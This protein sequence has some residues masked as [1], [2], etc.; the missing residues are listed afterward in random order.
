MVK[1]PAPEESDSSG[2]ATLFFDPNA[3]PATVAGVARAYDTMQ[4][5]AQEVPQPSACPSPFGP[6]G[7]VSEAWLAFHQAWSAEMA[8]ARSALEEMVKILPVTGKAI[9]HADQQGSP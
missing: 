8:T 5:I 9:V 1:V 4:T 2:N 6:F 3:F 7:A